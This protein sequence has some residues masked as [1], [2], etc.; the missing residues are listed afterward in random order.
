MKFFKIIFTCL[1]NECDTDEH[2]YR[3]F[4]PHLFQ[5]MKIYFYVLTKK[6]MWFKIRSVKII[7]MKL[8][9]DRFFTKIFMERRW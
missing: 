2:S 5:I 8:K 1:Q 3:I 7:Q 6:H 9:H 4:Y